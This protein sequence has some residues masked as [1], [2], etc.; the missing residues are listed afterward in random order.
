MI[1]TTTTKAY[2]VALEEGIDYEQFW[3]EIESDTVGLPHIPDRAVGIVNNRTAFKRLCEYALTDAEA[4]RLRNDPRV[5]D[6]EIP[7]RNN[8][9]V[10]V[11]YSVIQDSNF[12]KAV[13]NNGTE[14]NWG[15]IRHSNLENVYGYGY[16]TSNVYEYIL[17]G[18][19]VDIVISD[20]G[21]Q[22]DHPE[23][24]GRVVQVN[25]EYYYQ[26]SN[27]NYYS[28]RDTDGHGT[29]VA[30]IAAGKTYGW[31]KGAKVIPIY[32]GTGG[33]SNADPLDQFEAL[34][35]WHRS[36]NG[37]RPTI[38]NMSWELRWNYSGPDYRNFIRGGM[39]QGSP[40]AAW[41]SV[42]NMAYYRSRGLI[43]LVQGQL[44]I[45]DTG[46]TPVP[47]VPYYSSSYNAALAEVINA[48]ITVVQAAGNNNF[49]M[50]KPLNDGGTGDYDNY[51]TLSL[52]TGNRNFYYHRGASPKDPRSIVV[53]SLDSTTFNNTDLDQVADYSTKG[54]RIDVW[55]AGTRIVSACSTISTSLTGIY[56]HGT[57][58]QQSYKQAILS[59]TSMASP[60]IAGICALYLQ[61]HKNATPAEVKAWIKNNAVTG[62]LH[63]TE[64]STDYTDPRSLLGS[65]TG[66]AYWAE[67]AAPPPP[68]P[69]P[70]GLQT[71]YVKNNAGQWTGVADIWAKNNANQWV[72]AKTVWKKTDDGWIAIFAN[73][74]L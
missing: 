4:D 31:A 45:Q 57:V 30:G 38:V 69:D 55:A 5:L 53:G 3:T 66:I 1:I 40:I 2:I 47:G 42:Q 17:D 6:V 29:H 51:V 64:S 12:N 68:P 52:T 70:P 34:I 50:D 56:P 61:E 20:T 73:S 26:S 43:D 54:P 10:D 14:V 60:Q 13:S 44:S 67:R 49:K 28:R 18:T 58:S 27:L 59:G 36:K 7:V 11:H 25:W 63:N 71:T 23:F 32:Y 62:L 46:T 8:P 15:L 65:A 37:S 41:S 9:D 21:L 39:Y 33:R 16:A 35:N 22:I 72:T 19:G 74:S 48:G 24:A